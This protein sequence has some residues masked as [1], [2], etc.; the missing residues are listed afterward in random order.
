MVRAA[1]KRSEL[2]IEIRRRRWSDGKLRG[3]GGG[4]GDM[5]S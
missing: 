3:G 1:V 2:K 4:A 5:L